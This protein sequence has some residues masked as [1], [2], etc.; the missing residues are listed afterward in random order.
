[1]GK[2]LHHRNDSKTAVSLKPATVVMTKPGSLEQKAQL[3]GSSTGWRV[4]FP[5][6]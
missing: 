1:M 4:S 3:V 6:D 5:G 2:G